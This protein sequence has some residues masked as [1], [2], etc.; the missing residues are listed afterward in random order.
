MLKYL[1]SYCTENILCHYYKDEG[2]N[3]V[4]GNNRCLL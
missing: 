4:Y 3:A 1:S 2:V